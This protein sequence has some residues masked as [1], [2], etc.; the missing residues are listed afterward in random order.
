MILQRLMAAV[1]AQNWFAVVLE[2]VIVVLGIVIGFQVTAWNENRIARADETQIIERLHSEIIGLG[3]S[4]WDWAED[5]LE[6]RAH[7]LA[8]SQALFGD[9]SEGA[10]LEIS[11]AECTAIAQSHVFN[12]PSLALPVITELESTG[13][14]GLITNRAVR[15][16]ITN[17]LMA[18]AWARELDTAINHEVFNLTADYPALFHFVP[19]AEGVDWNPIFDGSVRCDSAAMRTDRAFLNALADNISKSLYFMAGVLDAPNESFTAL[20]AIVDVELGLRHED[21]ES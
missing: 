1:R 17:Y 2:L 18:N 14:L 10:A 20:H 19:P 9:V 12:S 21:V 4:R 11:G 16:A 15:Q 6:T 3:N 8:L 5:R 13:D 7:L